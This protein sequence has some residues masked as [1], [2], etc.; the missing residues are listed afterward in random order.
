VA[1]AILLVR[2][3]GGKVTDFTDLE[4]QYD[5]EEI[6]ASNNLVHNEI[7]KLISNFMI[8]KTRL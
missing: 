6:I 3:A 1:A 5:G 2:E 8:S 4:N 7:Q